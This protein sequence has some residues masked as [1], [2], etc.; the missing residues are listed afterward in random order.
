M[1]AEEGLDGVPPGVFGFRAAALS[2]AGNGREAEAD[3]EGGDGAFRHQAMEQARGAGGF[4]EGGVDQVEGGKRAAGAG[5][6]FGALSSSRF[7]WLLISR[8]SGGFFFDIPLKFSGRAPNFP[9]RGSG[10]IRIQRL[11]PAERI[12]HHPDKGLS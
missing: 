3:H 8:L 2:P 12:L 10:F 6:G 5:V 9:I 11:S 7:S 1:V 4:G